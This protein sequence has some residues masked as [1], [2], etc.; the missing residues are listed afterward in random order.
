MKPESHASLVANLEIG[1]SYARLERVPMESADVEEI[2]AALSRVRNAMNQIT[3]RLRRTTDMD[4][5]V[6]GFTALSSDRKS[7]YAMAVTTK[8]KDEIKI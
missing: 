6:E 8:V 5:T 1:E 7:I 2:N 3:N 4:F